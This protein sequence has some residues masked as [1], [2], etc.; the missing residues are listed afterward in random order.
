MKINSH[1]QLWL[2]VMAINGFASLIVLIAILALY[3]PEQWRNELVI[4]LSL[5]LLIATPA[6]YFMAQQIRRNT[7][8]T[9]ELQRLVDRD[10]LTDV[11]TRDFF[12]NAME[13]APDAYGVSLMIDIDHFKGV[14]DFHGHLAGDE[15]IK[16]VAQLLK[17]TVREQDIVARFGGEEF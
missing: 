1:K 10:R 9:D 6:A 7:Q 11:G 15:V 14:N 12:F 4:G 17:K 13:E 2:V 8:L 3:P 16:S 5:T